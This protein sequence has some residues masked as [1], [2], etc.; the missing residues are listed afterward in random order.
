MCVC[1]CVGACT[2]TCIIFV[3]WGVCAW[4]CVCVPACMYTPVCMYIHISNFESERY[5]R[6]ECH[7]QMTYT[8]PCY[9]R[10]CVCVRTYILCVCIYIC[11]F[12]YVGVCVCTHA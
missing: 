12:V 11:A 4:V 6:F 3:F 7:T 2:Y 5:R 10:E 9:V 8:Q 1:V